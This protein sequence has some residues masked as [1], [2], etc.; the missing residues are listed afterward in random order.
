MMVTVA[1]LGCASTSEDLMLTR[2][3][4][5]FALILALMAPIHASAVTA[6]QL[7][8]QGVEAFQEGD[9]KL[10]RTRFWQLVLET[11]PDLPLHR[12][13]TYNLARTLQKLKS[14]CSAVDLF[15]RYF[16]LIE[17]A[18]EEKGRRW[19][20][21][22]TSRSE[23]ARIC[24][25]TLRLE[26]RA[27]PAPENPTGP[28]PFWDVVEGWVSLTSAGGILI[29]E[30]PETLRGRLG[31]S[32]GHALS[33]RWGLEIGGLITPLKEGKARAVYLKGRLLYGFSKHLG[34]GAGLEALT[35][36][37]ATLVDLALQAKA[38]LWRGWAL[39]GEVA[40]LAPLNAP[41]MIPLELRV[42]LRYG[43]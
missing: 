40:A 42:S 21:A 19:T 9:L 29:D 27:N 31:L 3:S 28:D 37:W 39:C 6:D 22:Q 5:I 7:Y 8:Q 13:T 11:K 41:G 38:P 12:Q 24:A 26:Q 33:A 10:A 4:S 25:Q 14:H 43:F 2:L 15:D 32:Y 18:G 35:G 17:K 30:Q 1:S 34:L 20:R 36:D 16:E 23:S